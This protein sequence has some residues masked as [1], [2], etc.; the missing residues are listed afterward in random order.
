[1]EIACFGMSAQ[2]LEI[3]F[4]PLWLSFEYTEMLLAYFGATLVL[5]AA[6]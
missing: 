2:L 6:V 4:V 1:M 3:F 5:F